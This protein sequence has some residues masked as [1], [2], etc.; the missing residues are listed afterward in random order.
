MSNEDNAS[1]RLLQIDWSSSHAV[2]GVFASRAAIC[3]SDYSNY[4]YHH[5]Y[6][7]DI[8]ERNQLLVGSNLSAECWVLNLEY[9]SNGKTLA[10][11]TIDEPGDEKGLSITDEEGI[12]S[13]FALH[14]YVLFL[15]PSLNR[16]SFYRI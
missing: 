10:K 16:F 7:R 8:T 9:E 11:V 4:K 1:F 15:I 12:Q 13:K 5:F 6:T 3:S 14:F 2:Q